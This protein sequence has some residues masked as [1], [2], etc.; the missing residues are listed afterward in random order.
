MNNR[1]RAVE[2]GDSSGE[3]VPGVL[4]VSAWRRRPQ[5]CRMRGT[6]KPLSTNPLFVEHS[7][8]SERKSLRW[9]C[10]NQLAHR[11]S[12]TKSHRGALFIE[13]VVPHL[14]KPNAHH[15]VAAVVVTALAY[16][17]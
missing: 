3:T 1:C 11:P 2:R 16:C 8:K 17:A 12:P 13:S 10:R 4:A 9:T 7:R 14:V 6:S 5:L 15:R